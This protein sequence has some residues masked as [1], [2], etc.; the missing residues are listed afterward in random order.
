MEKPSRPVIGLIGGIG[1]GKS[2]VACMLRELGCPVIDA[3]AVGHLLLERPEV[4]RALVGRFGSDIVGPDG[5]VVRSVLGSRAFADRESLARLN[6][7]VHPSL[8]VELSRRIEE[9]R[10]DASA[11]EALVLDA[12][13]LLETDWHELCSVLVFVD[14]PREQRGRRVARDRG[15]P[16]AEL[17]RR[18]NLQKPLDIKRARSVYILENS[19]SVSRLRR[20]VRLLY[21]C[22]VDPA[23]GS[24]QGIDERS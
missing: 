20:Q 15:W 22:L 13:L 3:D 18:E 16:A 19:S 10:A 1:S 21:Q 24:S 23:A 6:R 14:A 5:K 8:R 2:L 9:F 11:G 4:V 17:D 12:A 7:I